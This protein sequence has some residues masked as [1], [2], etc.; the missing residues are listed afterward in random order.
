MCCGFNRGFSDEVWSFNFDKKTWKQLPNYPIKCYGLASCI[1]GD[2]MYCSGGYNSQFVEKIYKFDLKYKKWS[3]FTIDLPKSFFFNHS[4]NFFIYNNSFYFHGGESCSVNNFF[5][6]YDRNTNEYQT[7]DSSPYKNLAYKE[8]SFANTP[9]VL[10]RKFFYLFNNFSKNELW[11][12]DLEK[13]IWK[14]HSLVEKEFK[15]EP[16]NKYSCVFQ[17]SKIYIIGGKKNLATFS[18]CFV[19]KTYSQGNWNKE[20]NLFFPQ[21]FRDVVLLLLVI[22]KFCKDEFPTP[23]PI[24]FLILKFF[25]D[26]FDD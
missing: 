17:D 25:S 6:R 20:N 10:D 8:D 4:H 26:I 7:L 3:E 13:D 15:I 23:K 9:G 2:T 18:D 1:D 11:V 16:P 21:N 22:Q 19:L 5:G 24:L 14:S 12:Y